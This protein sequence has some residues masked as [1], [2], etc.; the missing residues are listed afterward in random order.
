MKEIQDLKFIWQCFADEYKW[1]DRFGRIKDNPFDD[2]KKHFPEPPKTSVHDT[3]EIRVTFP[4]SIIREKWLQGDGLSGTNEQLRRILYT[5]VETGCN[6]LEILHL[7]KPEDLS[8]SL[9]SPHLNP[10]DA[11]RSSNAS[12]Q[13]QL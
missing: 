12:R 3:T 11:A 8:G 13:D 5:L 1:T 10:A 2:L 4:T 9:H 7:S 6:P